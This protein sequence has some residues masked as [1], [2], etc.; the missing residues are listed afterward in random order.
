MWN[1]TMFYVCFTLQVSSATATFAMTFSSSM[2]VV[3]YYLLKRFPVPYGIYSS[4]EPF[5]TSCAMT[6]TVTFLVLHNYFFSEY[7]ILHFA[8]W[9]RDKLILITRLW[10]Y[11]NVP[12]LAWS[13]RMEKPME[14]IK[15]QSFGFFLLF[16]L[17]NFPIVFS[18]G[19][20]N[21][22]SRSQ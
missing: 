10:H 8:L 6:F 2:S 13:W 16:L 17:N 1:G 9:Y 12:P 15:S 20:L 7:S 18:I 11:Q 22:K 21:L 5:V 3:E 4:L 19:L 14:I